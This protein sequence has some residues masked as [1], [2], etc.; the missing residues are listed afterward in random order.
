MSAVIT[1][2][3]FAKVC[4]VINDAHLIAWDGCH[5]IYLAMDAIEADWFRIHY[6]EYLVEATEGPGVMLATLGQ[7]WEDSCSLRFI[8]AVAHNEADPNEGFTSLI[9]QFDDTDEEDGQ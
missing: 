2:P 7:W 9:G 6:E 4:A 8:S 5:K 3:L 1:T